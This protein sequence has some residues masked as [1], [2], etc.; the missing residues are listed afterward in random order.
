M[1][2]MARKLPMNGNQTRIRFQK[3]RQQFHLKRLRYRGRAWTVS[4]T[5][6]GPFVSTKKPSNYWRWW[7]TQGETIGKARKRLHRITTSESPDLNSVSTTFA[8]H[9]R[10]S[11][12]CLRELF[13]LNS[14]A[15]NRSLLTAGEIQC[16][17]RHSHIYVEHGGFLVVFLLAFVIGRGFF[18]ARR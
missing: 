3:R 10:G 6:W 2:K 7:R 17:V 15:T 12:A 18:P 16:P 1:W 11:G 14:N 4:V 8:A 5:D 9:L 13:I